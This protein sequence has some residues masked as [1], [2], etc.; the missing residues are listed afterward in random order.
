MEY[1]SAFLLLSIFIGLVLRLS[2]G[3][4][5]RRTGPRTPAVDHAVSSRP[6]IA[7]TWI[8]PNMSRRYAG[9]VAKPPPYMLMM[10]TYPA[11]NSAMLT[12]ASVTHTHARDR[13]SR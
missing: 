7:P 6:W 13:T 2:T 3:R 11:T 10:M 5:R 8:T 1:V 4:E 9:I 12:V